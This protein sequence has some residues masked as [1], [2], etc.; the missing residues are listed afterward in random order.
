MLASWT[1]SLR[2][3]IPLQFQLPD[4]LVEPGDQ[5]RITLGYVFLTVA[6]NSGRSLQKGLLP[7]LYL[8]RVN[9]ILGGQLATVSSPFTAA[10]ATL[11]LNPGYVSSVSSC[12]TPSPQLPLLLV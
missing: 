8:T 6:K 5:R 12:P 1:G 2:Q 10:N 11:A 3:E 7:G 4:L 9:L